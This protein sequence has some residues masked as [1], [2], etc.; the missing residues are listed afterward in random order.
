MI[1]FEDELEGVGERDF[2][3][4]LAL[5]APCLLKPLKEQQVF[6]PRAITRQMERDQRHKGGC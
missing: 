6:L 2:E 4:Y 3:K 5:T 1:D